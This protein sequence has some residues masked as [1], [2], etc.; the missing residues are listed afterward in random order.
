MR[1]LVGN[2]RCVGH[3]APEDGT[4]Q[5]AIKT[6]VDDQFTGLSAQILACCHSRVVPFDGVDK[7]IG[8]LEDLALNQTRVTASVRL[9]GG[10]SCLGT[11]SKTYNQAFR[12]R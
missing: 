5:V 6:G 4:I 11:R 7:L 2:V 1:L 9:V 10:N 3:V 8:F 12:S